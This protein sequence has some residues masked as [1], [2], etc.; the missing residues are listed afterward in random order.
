MKFHGTIRA[1]AS[2]DTIELWMLSEITPWAFD[3]LR[4]YVSNYGT[5]KKYI[6]SMNSLG[7][8]PFTAFAIHDYMKAQGVNASARIYGV[9]ASA[10]ALIACACDRVEMGEMSHMMIH[11][12]YGGG[13]SDSDKQILESINQRQAEV[14]ASKTGKTTKEIRKMMA[15]E[16]WMDAKT[17]KREGFAD[18]VI[19]D[20]AVAALYKANYM[21]EELKTTDGTVEAPVVEETPT[22]AEETVEV[23]VPVEVTVAQVVEAKLT[24]K[25]IVAKV[26]VAKDLKESVASLTEEIKAKSTEADEFKAE[27]EGLREKLSAA[28]DVKAK[29]ESERDAL[30]TELD[31]IKAEVKTMAEA[32][33]KLK[34][35]P[36]KASAEGGAPD[37]EVQVP[38]GGPTNGRRISAK[39]E[40][41]EARKMAVEGAVEKIMNKRKGNKA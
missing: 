37:K 6:I 5:D 35:E 33:D 21:Q 10:A 2:S 15:A 8:D 36:I 26:K 39:D 28:D 34:G 31:A 32:M 29:V 18:S 19:S 7:G 25:P 38:G 41:K 23:E 13:G 17:A 4:Y 40:R 27:A 20:L 1:S 16:T 11:D 14:F 24:G 3:D 12:A 9:A 22:E 30:K